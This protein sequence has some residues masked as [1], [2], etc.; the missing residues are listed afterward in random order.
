MELTLLTVADCPHAALFEERLAVAL[1]G[2]PGAAL[3][4]RV[5]AG[6]REAGVGTFASPWPW[7]AARP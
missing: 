2:H 4:R 5:V 7:P 3:R 6:E 1:A